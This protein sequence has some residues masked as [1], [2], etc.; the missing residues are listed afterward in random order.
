MSHAFIVEEIDQRRGTAARAVAETGL[1]GLLCCR[2]ESIAWLG[3]AFDDGTLPA[4]VLIDADGA[5][6]TPEHGGIDPLAAITALAAD[7]GRDRGRLG[8]EFAGGL[9]GATARG[10]GATLGEGHLEDASRLVERLRVI[11]SPAEMAYIRRA[12]GLADDALEAARSVAGPGVWDGDIL[13]ALQGAVFRG[14]G[15]QPAHAPTVSAGS[16]GTRADD[17]RDH[18]GDGG[19]L[20]L[21]WAGTYRRYHAPMAQTLFL[22]EADPR[23]HSLYAAAA[24]ALD[25]CIDA[26]RPG[27]TAGAVF[28]AQARVL[29][30]TAPDAARPSSCGA[31]AGLAFAP[32]RADAP[33]LHSGSD[34]VLAA[35]MALA[36]RVEA[37]DPGSGERVVLGRTVEISEAGA[38]LL[39]AHGT[40]L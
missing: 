27:V 1:D 26:A 5:L 23:R 20:Q 3:G 18:L 29:D 10:L 28:D 21:E 33:V 35:G 38:V 4:C 13:A 17:A 7:H 11:K 14:G 36:L 15:G 40:A 31:S 8:V 34:D 6:R 2:S 39:H 24:E 37:T 30:R 12:A 32:A 22:D 25:A 9:D 19:L 16:A